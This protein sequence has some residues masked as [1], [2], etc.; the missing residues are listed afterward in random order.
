MNKECNYALRER[1]QVQGWS[2]APKPGVIT[3]VSWVFHPRLQ[4]YTWGYRVLFDEGYSNPFTFEY[5]PEGYL[6]KT[7]KLWYL[8]GPY[9]SKE[10]GVTEERM[11]LFLLADYKLLKAGWRTV[12]PLSKHFCLGM[13]EEPIDGTYNFWKDY[14]RQL[15]QMCHGII[16]LTID[17]WETSTGVTDELDNAMAGKKAVIHFD[18]TGDPPVLR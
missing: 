17:G 18:P 10:P 13:G 7:E 3:D 6:R 1:V 4:Q 11:R 16:V 5:I 9:T 14:S 12:S 15:L 2:G 8:A